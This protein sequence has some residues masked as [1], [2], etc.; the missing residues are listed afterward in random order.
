M[1]VVKYNSMQFVEFVQERDRIRVRK[2]MQGELAPWTDDKI[3][4]T[5]RF[6]NIR[7]EDDKVTKWIRNNWSAR[8][9]RDPDLWFTMVVARLLNYPESLNELTYKVLPFEWVAFGAVLQKRKA[10][11]MKNFSPAYIVSTNGQSMDKVEYL[12]EFVLRPMWAERAKYRPQ[13]GD[14]L[15]SWHAKL[16]HAQGMGSF[17]AAQVVADVK[18]T[19]G[20]P[21]ATAKDWW[22]WAAPGPGSLRGLNRIL[23]NGPT[24]NG[25]SDARFLQQLN[26]LQA[27]LEDHSKIK[28]CAQDVQN[29]LCEFDKYERV[30]LGEGRPKQIYRTNAGGLF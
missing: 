27:F 8:F 11:G 28:L 10:Q 25:L 5:Y 1:G 3:L 26:A 29:C 6:C 30:R 23:G 22:T 9:G 16:M 20:T 7:R 12:L 13:E 18:N 14:T 21:L 24:K 2:D 19:A 17:M 15:A 4:R